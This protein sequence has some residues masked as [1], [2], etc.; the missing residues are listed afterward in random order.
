MIVGIG[1]DLIDVSR[2]AKL[3][4][5][6]DSYLHKVFTEEEMKYSRDKS[7]EAQHFAARFAAKEAFMKALGTGWREGISFNE[8][9][10]VN[11]ELGKPDLFLSGK[12]AEKL[13]QLGVTSV[14]LSLTHLPDIAGAF[15]ILEK[16]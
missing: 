1:F 5:S 11:N 12:A 10:V 14:K 13:S 9:G 15:V 8:I 3:V 4:K 16:I 6:N 2:V 7:G